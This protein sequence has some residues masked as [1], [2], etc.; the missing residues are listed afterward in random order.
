MFFSLHTCVFW[1]KC[2]PF[3]TQGVLL[4]PDKWGYDLNGLYTPKN[5][6]F[7]IPNPKSLSAHYEPSHNS[8]PDSFDFQRRMGYNMT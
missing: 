8:W 6:Q 4:S 5:P 1:E 2:T 7:E 3:H